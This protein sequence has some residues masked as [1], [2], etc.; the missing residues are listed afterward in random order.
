[1]EPL[2]SRRSCT[3][4]RLLLLGFALT[5]LL[6]AGCMNLHKHALDKSTTAAPGEAVRLVTAWDN[7]MIFA[8]DTTR[9]GAMM[10]GIMGRMYLFGPDGGVPLEAKGG[11]I[12]DMY[13]HTLLTP[14]ATP[15]LL[16]VWRIDPDSLKLLVKKD[17]FGV[18][19]SIFLPW[20]TY[21]TDIQRVNL[22]IRYEPLQGAPL[23]TQSNPFSVDHSA[24]REQQKNGQGI[25]MLPPISQ[26]APAPTSLGRPG[27]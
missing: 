14:G 10:P 20:S 8:P 9:G 2:A 6:G 5:G 3:A 19:Y 24:T 12:V 25:P 13:D 22:M 27:S 11:L 15:K 26:A 1:M 7:K 23:L 16:E 18:G 21:R 4:V 17:L